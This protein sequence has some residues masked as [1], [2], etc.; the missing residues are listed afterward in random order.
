M[1]PPESV[2]HAFFF[3]CSEMASYM[4]GSVLLADGGCTLYPMD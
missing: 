2:A 3:L 4:T 1:Q